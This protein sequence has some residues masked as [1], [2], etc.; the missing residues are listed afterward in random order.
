MILH[1]IGGVASIEAH[2]DGLSDL[3]RYEE[4]WKGA[5][6]D[7]DTRKIVPFNADGDFDGRKRLSRDA[8]SYS[9]FISHKKSEI[10]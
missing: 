10:W 7:L 9:P 6:S 8:P 1:G 5:L 3:D 2:E 4:N